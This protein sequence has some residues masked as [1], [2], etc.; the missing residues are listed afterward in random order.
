MK[1]KSFVSEVV[2]DW[3]EYTKSKK[4]NAGGLAGPESPVIGSKG[5]DYVLKKLKSIYPDYEFVKTDLS[6]SPAD[7]IGLKKTKSYLHFALFQVKTSTNKKTLTSNIPEKQTLPIL[8]ELIKNRFKVSEQTNKIRT[9]SLFITIGYIGV[10]KE[11]NHKVFKSM[12]YPKTFSLNN[13]N[14]SSLEKTEIKNKIH[15]L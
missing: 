7:I 1:L 3:K 12:P 9:N 11:T 2:Y 13:L 14:L 15:R 6:K 5:E 8:A 4:N 10:S